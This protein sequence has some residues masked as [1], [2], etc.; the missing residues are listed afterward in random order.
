LSRNKA[1]HAMAIN[2]KLIKEIVILKKNPDLTR[3]SD[4]LKAKLKIMKSFRFSKSKKNQMKI[5]LKI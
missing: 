5:F 1:I 2:T 4:V 3:K